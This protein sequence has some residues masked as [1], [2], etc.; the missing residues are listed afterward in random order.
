MLNI[1]YLFNLVKVWN[2]RNAEEEKR[3]STCTGLARSDTGNENDDNVRVIYLV[4]GVGWGANFLG[5]EDLD[6]VLE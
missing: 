6:S 4:R 2:K 5:N 3:T 1:I